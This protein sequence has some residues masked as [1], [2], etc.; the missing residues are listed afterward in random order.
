MQ[1]RTLIGLALLKSN[2]DQQQRSYLDNFVPFLAE[3]M[4]QS[5][6]TAFSALE[7]TLAVDEKFGIHLP[8]PV[9][10]SI[11]GKAA[12]TGL[13]RREGQLFHVDR[14]RLRAFDLTTRSTTAQ[15]EQ[16]S[17]VASFKNF[18]SEQFDRELNDDDALLTLHA[19]VDKYSM[20][21][22]SS[23]VRG[24]AMP[25]EVKQES[26]S[27][28]LNYICSAFV[29]SAY[30]DNPQMFSHIENL[31]KGSMLSS[32]VYLSSPGDPRK[33][34]TDTKLYLDTPLLLAALGYHGEEEERSVNETLGLGFSL[35]ARLVTFEETVNETRGILQGCASQISIRGTGRVEKYFRSMGYRPSDI[36]LFVS[37][38]EK[39]IQSRRIQIVARPDHVTKLT[40]D[41]SVLEATLREFIPTYSQGALMHDLN[42]LTAIHRLRR[43]GTSYDIESCKAIFVTSNGPLIN[44][45]RRYF[46]IEYP[47]SF[48]IAIGNYEL[49]TLLWL[50]RPLE[51]PDLPEKQIVADCY[52]ALEPGNTLWLRFLEEAERL[53]KRGA[54]NEDDYFILRY[55]LES[56]NILMQETLGDAKRL[57]PDVVEDILER[58]K[59]AMSKPIL[60]KLDEANQAYETEAEKVESISVELAETRIKLQAASQE[61]ASHR[62]SATAKRERITLRA[63][64]IGR[65]V[66]KVATAV[67]I[68]IVV[69]GAWL[70]LPVWI[71]FGQ[72][73]ISDSLKWPLGAVAVTSVILLVIFHFTKWKP[74]TIGQKLESWI[75][76]KTETHYL[77]KEGLQQKRKDLK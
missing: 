45:S 21:I 74:R 41:E 20:P 10:W 15:R 29:M 35:G 1:S 31:V 37:G 16:S 55:E 17:L 7:L 77:V 34:F 5:E 8:E 70:A 39:N 27:L 48:P 6:K 58:S 3:C 69:A 43:G 13:G 40:V 46:E 52:A 62:R 25:S 51:R 50:K 61:L 57:S 18:V 32:V 60:D 33:P 12:R 68:V 73:K 64:Q 54:I 36:Q 42:A 47:N 53:Q 23:I 11:L 72:D 56:R 24:T 22:L 65:N 38:L 76:E 26:S 49:T 19:Y 44:A 71:P 63:V 75:S 67:L 28:D 30:R 2:W 4:R 9:A 66:R 59:N 14:S